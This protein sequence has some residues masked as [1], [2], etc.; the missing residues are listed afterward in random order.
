[1]KSI[2]APRPVGIPEGSKAQGYWQLSSKSAHEPRLSWNRLDYDAKDFSPASDGEIHI[3]GALEFFLFGARWTLT[4]AMS[5]KPAE[6]EVGFNFDTAQFAHADPPPVR[7][8][9]ATLKF[10]GALSAKVISV[11]LT[12]VWGKA[13]NDAPL[14]LEAGATI[15]LTAEEAETGELRAGI[16]ASLLFAKPNNQKKIGLKVLK[17]SLSDGALQLNFEGFQS[18]PANLQLLPGMRLKGS[19]F[20]GYAVM[21]FSLKEKE[22]AVGQRLKFICGLV[23][24]IIPC[25]W[26]ARM[27]GGPPDEGLFGSSSGSLFAGLT[28]SGKEGNSWATKL[29]LNGSLE[30]RNLISWPAQK[31]LPDGLR[32]VRFNPDRSSV[33]EIIKEDSGVL[34][35]VVDFLK[36]AQN[37]DVSLRLEGHADSTTTYQASLKTSHDRANNVRERLKE[38]LEPHGISKD[39]I[40]LA[41]GFSSAL[42]ID[43]NDDPEGRQNNRR[44]EFVIDEVLL[45]AANPGGTHPPLNHL[46]HTMTALLNQ[47][48]VPSEALGFSWLT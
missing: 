8:S 30:V 20:K 2:H 16:N 40:K 21:A 7:P 47:H 37:R 42:P 34:A 29:L 38:L 25:E 11:D 15:D 31:R 26:G 13:A 48:E 6:K 12:F 39:R 1:L 46:R 41:I 14:K 45:P 18:A 44:V 23:E 17:S 4:G 36:D 32:M 28:L 5:F 19:E 10:D 9:G 22:A 24:A 33:S 35:K 43:T 27:S 3:G